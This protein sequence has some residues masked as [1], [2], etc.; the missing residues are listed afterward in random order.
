MNNVYNTEHSLAIKTDFPIF[1][2][3]NRGG[4]KY[5]KMSG[6]DKNN[7]FRF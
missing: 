4:S 2:R 7:Y 5:K 6:L 1:S 3:G